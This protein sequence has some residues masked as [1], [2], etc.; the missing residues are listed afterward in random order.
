MSGINSVNGVSFGEQQKKSS[1]SNPFVPA[2]AV[3]GLTGLGVYQFMKAPMTQDEFVKSSNVKY[4]SAL[5][6]DEQKLVDAMKAPAAPS[7]DAPKA[8]AAKPATDA[9]KVDEVKA[10]KKAAKVEKENE[11]ILEDIFGKIKE[12]KEDK[13]VEY[14]DYL[15]DAHGVSSVG[16]LEKKIKETKKEVATQKKDTTDPANL[17]TEE[18]KAKKTFDRATLLQSKYDQD[19]AIQKEAKEARTKYDKKVDEKK[20]TKKDL[21]KVEDI[22]QKAK[23]SAENLNKAYKKAG[24]DS[25][26]I[27]DLESSIKTETEKRIGKKSGDIDFDVKRAIDEEKLKLTDEK[28]KLEEKAKAAGEKAREEAKKAGKSAGEQNQAEL[29]AKN[30]EKFVTLTDKEIEDKA[31]AAGEKTRTAAE[32]RIETRVK[33]ELTEKTFEDHIKSV[34]KSHRKAAKELANKEGEIARM[35]HDLG[36]VT[37][38]K[39]NKT[40]I[41]RAAA[42]EGFTKAATKAN[43]S[44]KAATESKAATDIATKAYEA[45]KGK[46]E[47]V[48]SLKKAGIWGG[49]AAVATFIIASMMGGK[50]ETV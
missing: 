13:G 11:K 5:T 8:D 38:A 20:A 12:G 24:L 1:S 4:T 22:E 44:V 42:K 32:K 3:G 18:M 2:V 40:M 28:N 31:K 17:K 16:Q 46:L 41:T 6:P 14:K 37:D 47:K 10:A 25:S 43:E 23:K 39:A 45:V 29:T 50:E 7:T 15:S 27:T 34:K 26:K 49:V 33:N 36:L 19:A 9:P 35:E 21:F 48:G 30:D